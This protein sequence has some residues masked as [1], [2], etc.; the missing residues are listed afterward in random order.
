MTDL[1][2]GSAGGYIGYGSAV[3]VSN[4]SVTKL[5]HTTVKTPNANI[6]D[7]DSSSYFGESSSYAIS[8]PKN[9]GG[10]VG[11]LD[12]GSTASASSLF[13]ILPL[14][15]LV[16]PSVISTLFDRRKTSG[17]KRGT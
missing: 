10:Y 17:Q 11:K 14:G 15:G 6:N 1:N 16:I 4:S 3:R 9:A 13:T 12:I 2:S 8:A 5:K 7:T